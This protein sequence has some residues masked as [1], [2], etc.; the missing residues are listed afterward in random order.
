[1]IFTEGNEGNEDRM[2]GLSSFVFFV[3]FCK[4]I[5][6]QFLVDEDGQ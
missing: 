4:I 1:M 6:V 3:T 5:R 2:I